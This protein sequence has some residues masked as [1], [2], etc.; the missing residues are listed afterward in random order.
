MGCRKLWVESDSA[1]AVNLVKS[2]CI[3]SHPFHGLVYRI[4][5]LQGRSWET[6]LTHTR[7]EGNRVV[8]SM[9]KHALSSDIGLKFY[10]VPPSPFLFLSAS[11]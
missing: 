3:P 5:A 7:R 11:R 2:G 8:D 10:D 6:R 9:A 4:R 1:V